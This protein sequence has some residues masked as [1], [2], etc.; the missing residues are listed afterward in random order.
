[1]PVFGQIKNCQLYENPHLYYSRF[2]NPGRQQQ[3]ALL[4]KHKDR[5]QT[6]FLAR[7][8]KQAWKQRMVLA[9]GTDIQ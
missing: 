8:L 6:F 5:L 1:M 7:T 4:S 9:F 3:T 2:N